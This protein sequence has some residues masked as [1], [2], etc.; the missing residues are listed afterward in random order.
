MIVI[1][2]I[3]VTIV[4]SLAS[5]HIPK[6]IVAKL[7]IKDSLLISISSGVPPKQTDGAETKPLPTFFRAK[8]KLL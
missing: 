6:L 2:I 4:N 5:K 7:V 8:A 3:S 1:L